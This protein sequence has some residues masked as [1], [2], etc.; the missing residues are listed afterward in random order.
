MTLTLILR[1]QLMVFL[2]YFVWGTW[3]VT[4]VTYLSKTL[5]FTGGQIGLAYGTTAIGAMVSPFFAGIV[6]DRFFATQRLL[7]CLHRD[8]A[9]LR[10]HGEKLRSVLSGPDRLHDQL[11]GLSWADEL[12]HVASREKSGEGFSH[13]DACRQHRLDCGRPHGELAQL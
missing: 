3:Y 12:A 1:L 2:H 13:R 7:G 4:M 11:Y 9:L 10:L 5:H 6:A 8:V